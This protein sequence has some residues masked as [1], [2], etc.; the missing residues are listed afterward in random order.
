MGLGFGQM[1]CGCNITFRLFLHYAEYSLFASQGGGIL[2]RQ[3]ALQRD[4]NEDVCTPAYIPSL[5]W[6]RLPA[7]TGRHPLL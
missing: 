6:T 1:A 4:S 5:Q 7:A 3:P 2:P